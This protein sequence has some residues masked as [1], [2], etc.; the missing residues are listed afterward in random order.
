MYIAERVD[1]TSE[2]SSMAN[3]GVSTTAGPRGG[4][5]LVK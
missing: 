4:G 3:Q 1:G 5:R 2:M